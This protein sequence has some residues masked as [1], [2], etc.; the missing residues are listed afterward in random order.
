MVATINEVRLL[1]GDEVPALRADIASLGGELWIGDAWLVSATGYVREA[2]GVVLPDPRPGITLGRPLFVSAEERGRGLEVGIR[3]LEGRITGSAAYTLGRAEHRVEGLAFPTRADRRHVVDA[4]ALARLGAGWRLGAAYTF[5]TGAP[6]TRVTHLDSNEEGEP[7][8]ALGSPNARR[9]PS[10]ASLDVM[11]DWVVDF[12]GWGLGAY[13][14]VRN[15]LGRD[16]AAGYEETAAY[17]EQGYDYTGET[18]TCFP[19]GSEPEL[20]DEFLFGLP[21]IP[22]V[23]FRVEF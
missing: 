13:L 14:Q 6:Y 8:G 21:T 22:L 3:R 20:R 17:C 2:D 5:A 23:G 9:T 18:V 4:T 7:V 19:D 1:A 11:L 16:N 12:G 10:Y 15:V